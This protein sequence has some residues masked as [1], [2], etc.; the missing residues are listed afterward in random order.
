MN[1]SRKI[2]IIGLISAV[3]AVALFVMRHGRDV[4]ANSRLFLA[5]EAEGTQEGLERWRSRFSSSEFDLAAGKVYAK[6]FKSCDAGGAEAHRLPSNYVWEVCCTAVTNHLTLTV[7]GSSREDVLR[8]SHACINTAKE[9]VNRENEALARAAT[10]RF[11]NSVVRIKRKLLLMTDIGAGRVDGKDVLLASSEYSNA[12]SRLD[13]AT[14]IVRHQLT[15][16]DVEGPF[17]MADWCHSRQP[18]HG[19]GSDH[20]Q[21]QAKISEEGRW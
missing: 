12:V 3:V 1:K 15:R 19:R 4:T 8:V 11:S 2:V 9:M 21:S 20:D 6:C 17:I 16:I 14:E 10:A 18:D 5:C 7:T 13:K